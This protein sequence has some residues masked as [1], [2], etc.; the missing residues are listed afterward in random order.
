LSYDANVIP[1][2][3]APYKEFIPPA[4]A[5]RM[6]KGVKMGIAASTQALNEAG[7]EN[8]DALIT[9]SG[10][11]CVV[12][13]EK[14][15]KGIIDNDELHL[16]PTS[17][18]QSTHNTVG[19]QIALNIQCTGYNY[20]YVHGAV[21][22][23]SAVLDAFLQLKN[24]EAKHILVG[25]V[26]ELGD[27]NV[28]LHK[29]IGHIKSEAVKSKDVYAKPSSGGVFSEG[30]QFFVLSNEKSEKNYAEILSIQTY[31]SLAKGKVQEKAI[32]FLKDQNLSVSDIDVLVL[33][34][35]GD[36]DFDG[37]YSEL[38]SSFVKRPVCRYKH[39][40]GEYNT[41]SSFGMWLAAR[42][43]KEQRIPATLRADERESGTIRHILLYNQYRGKDHSFTLLRSC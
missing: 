9:G 43:M 36:Q 35:N 27:H 12:D 25:G 19:G 15:L 40:C 32:Q 37:Y 29:L 1:A 13:S 23:E 28:N 5:R 16:T 38:A 39:L 20:T 33:G 41:A 14:F 30:A 7:L 3:D 31:N 11:G 24:E 10:M 34:N 26:D 21:S 8:V 18:I 17:F 6:A 2:V 42:I 4:A 22:F